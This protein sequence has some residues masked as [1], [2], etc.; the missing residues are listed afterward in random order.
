M[1][2]VVICARQT[3]HRLPGKALVSVGDRSI[4]Q[5]IVERYQA[6]YRIDAVIV[7][8]TTAEEDDGIERLSRHLGVPCHRGSLTDVVGQMNDALNA[9]APDADYVFRGMG[10]MPLFDTDLLD[11]RFDLLERRNADVVWTGLPDEQ[12]PVYGS[13]ESPWSRTVWDQI[14]ANSTGDERQ[15]T[16]QWLYSRL[17]KFRV[18]YVEGPLN[19]YYQT[20][21]LELD[22]PPDLAFFRAVYEALYTGPGTP[23]T[24]DTLRWLQEHPE[25]VQLN[26]DIDVKTLTQ[27]NWR[28]RGISW[29]CDA[30]GA[31]MMRADVIRHGQLV[32]TCPRCGAQRSFKQLEDYQ[33]EQKE[34]A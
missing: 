22:T 15:H 6:C 14:V 1:N 10:D 25:V 23:R 8:T 18:I 17:T 11:W 29:K 13:R 7:S 12:W 19:E 3:S 26:S 5:H 32:T 2:A 20:C 24:L 30:C 16:G 4:L 27:I 31:G 9:Y 33:R 21:R 34:E 28:Q